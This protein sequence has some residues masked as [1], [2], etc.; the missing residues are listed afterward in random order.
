MIDPSQ[1]A[2]E[3]YELIANSP[4][5]VPEFNFEFLEENKVGKLE[6]NRVFCE[7]MR[8]FEAL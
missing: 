6:E 8:I 7:R 2:R 1:L 4:A 3:K 5:P